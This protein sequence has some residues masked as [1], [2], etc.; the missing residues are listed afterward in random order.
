MLSCQSRGVNF[1]VGDFACRLG[2]I[3]NTVRAALASR[4]LFI[5][6]AAKIGVEEGPTFVLA[7]LLRDLDNDAEDLHTALLSALKMTA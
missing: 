2:P 6:L 7:R 3:T 1:C 4:E 5:C